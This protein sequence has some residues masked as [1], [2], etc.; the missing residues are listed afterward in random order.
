MFLSSKKNV[1]TNIVDDTLIVSFTE[2]GAPKI[3]RLDMGKFISAALEVKGVQGNFILV[4]KPGTGAAEEVGVFSDKKRA[5]E[6]LQ[7]ITDA[8]L[9]GRSGVYGRKSGGWFSRFL[10]LLLLLA[11]MA[12][13]LILWMRLH[14]T[15]VVVD[16]A[17]TP[18]PSIRTGT[19]LPADE[20][21]G[22]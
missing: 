9:K 22:K 19:P 10:K 11:L 20:V 14:G 16:S 3:W 18:S 5:M 13:G 15:P 7:S 6:V 21:L 4:V 17:V 2:G 8:F 1:K 12:A